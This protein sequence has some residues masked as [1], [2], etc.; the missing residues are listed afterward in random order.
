VKR[1]LIFVLVLTPA[2][3]FAR[4]RQPYLVDASSVSA[5]ACWREGRKDDC[6][7]FN[8]L[9]PGKEFQYEVSSRPFTGKTLPAAGAP[10][11]FAVFGDSGMATIGQK[12]VGAVLEKLEPDLVV[13]TGDVVYPTGVDADYDSKYFQIYGKTLSRVPVFPCPGNHDYGN[14]RRSAA[15]GEKRFRD[16][17]ARV[18]RR[19]KYY[20]FDAGP[21]HFVSLD[22]NGAIPVAAAEPIG[23]DSVQRRWLEADLARSRARW[24]FVFM[25]VPL[26]STYLNHGDNPGLRASLQGLFEKYRVDAV[27]AGHDHLYQRS[28]RMGKVVYLTVGT[29]G[30]TIMPGPVEDHPWLEKEV[31]A[32]GLLKAEVDEKRLA[33]EFMNEDG[34]LRDS[35]RIDKP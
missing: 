3:V 26:Y 9:E 31:V 7:E 14:S 12:K 24:K 18:F 5:K 19:P 16:G 1:A 17:Y 8:G 13:F 32:F 20:S 34:Q 33:L 23:L 15:I 22:T 10:L 27:F 11:R 21:A 29:G 35:Y 25:H 28:K 4:D 2:A 6:R 30:G